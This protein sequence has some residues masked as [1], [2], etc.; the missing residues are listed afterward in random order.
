MGGQ[1]GGIAGAEGVDVENA[2][3]AT[4]ARRA[5][6][7]NGPRASALLRPQSPASLCPQG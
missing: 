3:G 2:H 6:V 5:G 7:G 1:P 4:M